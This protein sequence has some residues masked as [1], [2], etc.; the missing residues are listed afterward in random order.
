MK[1]AIE[2]ILIGAQLL[3]PFSAAEGQT[4]GN[5]NQEKPAVVSIETQKAEPEEEIYSN[6]K[7]KDA[8]CRFWM[9]RRKTLSFEQIEA[10]ASIKNFKVAYNFQYMGL[11]NLPKEELKNIALYLNEV[12]KNDIQRQAFY[13]LQRCDLIDLSKPIEELQKENWTEILECF[14]NEYQAMILE[15]IIFYRNG[16]TSDNYKIRSK[17]QLL[18]WINALS[19][20]DDEKKFDFLRRGRFQVFMTLDNMNGLRLIIEE[21]CALNNE[22]IY[23]QMKTFFCNIKDGANWPDIFK[24]AREKLAALKNL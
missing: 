1:E 13:T 7:D 11:D 4:V 6:L 14:K 15:D 24:E 21:I 23:K 3:G 20:V 17:R 16:S 8:R 2:K 18:D 12:I 22:E 19:W 10:L 5:Q 9:E